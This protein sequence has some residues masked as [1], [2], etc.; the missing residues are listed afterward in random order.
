M[1]TST[2]QPII[3]RVDAVSI[4]QNDY[5]RKFPDRVDAQIRAAAASGLT[6]LTIGY[7]GVSNAVAAAVATELTAGGWTVTNDSTAKTITIS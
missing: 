7:G 5:Q 3:T 1:P 4:F 2:G 6:S